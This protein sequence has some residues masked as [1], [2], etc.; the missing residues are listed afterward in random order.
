MASNQIA[1]VL[2]AGRKSLD[3]KALATGKLALSGSDAAGEF[4]WGLRLDAGLWPQS[5]AERAD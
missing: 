4:S 3:S 2:S 1:I 5:G